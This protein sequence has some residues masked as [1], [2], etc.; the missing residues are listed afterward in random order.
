MYFEANRG[1][2]GARAKFLSRGAG[3]TLFITRD[4]ATLALR[5]SSPASSSRP[6]PVHLRERRPTLKAER[7]KIDGGEGAGALATQEVVLRM[8]LIGANRHARAIG[9][10]ALPGKANYFI[11]NDPKQWHTG[12]PLY[13]KVE[14]KDVYPRIDLVYYGNEQGRLEYDFIVAP[15]ANPN[16]IK[17]SF[18][19]EKTLKLA[20]N[21][22]LIASVGDAKLIE[23][24][25]VIYQEDGGKRRTIAGGW[26][27]RG[28]HEAV[29]TV[30]RYD[31]T[32]PLTI[33]PGLVYST[34][35]GGSRYGGGYAIA[36]DSAGNVYVAGETSS[37][38][39]PTTAGA[40]QTVNR[41]T[42]VARLNVFITKLSANGAALAYS[43]YLG[44]SF[45][46]MGTGIAIDSSGDAYVTGQANSYDFPTTADAFQTVNRSTAADGYN[47]FVTKL[48][49]NGSEL[50][51]ST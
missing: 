9:L 22:D 21:G 46:D 13:A 5:G 28:P 45:E 50:G 6:S 18:A 3:Y 37:T 24:A 16:A 25:P 29:F 15:G 20:K 47:A 10:D 8:R 30:A 11:G 14:L 23:H 35:P 12:V 39:F 17:L 31:R 43:T 42:S 40:V 1:Q 4:G 26:K 51:Y 7:R 32:K 38:D 41:S 19:G 34:Y 27:L 2:T 49:A 44:G 48:N 36:V 33:D